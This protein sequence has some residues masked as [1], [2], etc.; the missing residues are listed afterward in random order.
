M[1]KSAQK[2]TQAEQYKK[3]IVTVKEARKLLGSEYQN[4]S[5]EQIEEMIVAMTELASK[6]VCWAK[7][8]TKSKGVV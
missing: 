3:P 7:S 8:S 6:A 5:D 4:A 1:V 2:N